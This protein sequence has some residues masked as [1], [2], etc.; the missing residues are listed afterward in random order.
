VFVFSKDVGF[1]IYKLRRVITTQ[2][3]IYFHLWNNGTPH[4]EREKR[5]WEIEQEKEWT[6]VMS[7]GKKQ[8][9]KKHS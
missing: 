5:A 1:L 3:D 4:W 2:L 8:N 7:R 6:R 9:L